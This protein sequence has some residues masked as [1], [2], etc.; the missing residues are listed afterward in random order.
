MF[1]KRKQSLQEAQRAGYAQQHI[2]RKQL[3]K[4]KKGA[5]KKQPSRPKSANDYLES[6]RTPTDTEITQLW[7]TVK[8]VIDENDRY[9]SRGADEPQQNLRQLPQSYY[10]PRPPTVNNGSFVYSPGFRGNI[11]NSSPSWI[12]QKFRIPLHSRWKN[13]VSCKV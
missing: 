7:Q 3:Q 12:G 2:A 11:N 4:Q 8:H 1:I 9:G 13:S 10:L 5:V 6:R